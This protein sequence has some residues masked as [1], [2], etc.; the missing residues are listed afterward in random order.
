MIGMGSKTPVG[1][2]ESQ[3]AG[4][5]KIFT[6]C[7]GFHY[8]E[9][10]NT[11][12]PEGLPQTKWFQFYTS[13]FNTLEINSTFYKFP[14]SKSL[15]KWYDTSP[16]DFIFSVKAPRLVTHYKR[17]N[18]CEQYLTDFYN[19]CGDGLKN[20]LGCVLFQLPPQI[21]YSEEFLNTIIKLLD[22]SFKNAVRVSR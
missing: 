19:T 12:Y 14:T 21:K 9:W 17:F 11:F 1:K 16:D 13:Q 5:G 22:Q 4:L 2:K 3:L 6:G 10:K 18:E 15:Q 8:K 7:S 20:K